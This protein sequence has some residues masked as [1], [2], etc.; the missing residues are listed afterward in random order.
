MSEITFTE[1]ELRAFSDK[2]QAWGEGLDGREQQLLGNLVSLAA[3][4]TPAGVEAEGDGDE[5]AGFSLS[6]PSSPSFGSLSFDA[7]SR[8]TN[9]YVDLTHWISP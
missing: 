6:R 1:Q 2:L 5:V 3:T 7:L 9:G 8:P 4:H